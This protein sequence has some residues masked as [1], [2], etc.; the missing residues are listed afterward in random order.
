MGKLTPY[1]IKRIN[2][3]TL[4]FHG[5][6][7]AHAKPAHAG[8]EEQAGHGWTEFE[9]YRTSKGSLVMVILKKGRSYNK[10]WAF[11][12]D[13]WEDLKVA[14][15]EGGKDKAKVSWTSLTTQLIEEA[16]EV[17]PEARPV[18][19]LD[20]EAEQFGD[21]ERKRNEDRRPGYRNNGDRSQG[22][23]CR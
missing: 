16:I 9:L 20:L 21:Q 13:S 19:T 10:N 2:G 11:V 23:P 4:V 1:T 17:C 5:D 22:M 18:F 8:T 7:L 14:L 3:P 6:K 12:A 15:D